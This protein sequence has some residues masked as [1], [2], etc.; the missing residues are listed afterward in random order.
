[1]LPHVRGRSWHLGQCSYTFRSLVV[2]RVDRFLCPFSF[3]GV[4]LFR[5]HGSKVL[6]V[7]G[8]LGLPFGMDWVKRLF[9]PAFCQ[10]FHHGVGWEGYPLEEQ[11]FHN[12]QTGTRNLHWKQ[13]L[14]RC[15]SCNDYMSSFWGGRVGCSGEVGPGLLLWWTGL[16]WITSPSLLPGWLSRK[17]W[18][19]SFRHVPLLHVYRDLRSMSSTQMRLQRSPSWHLSFGFLFCGPVISGLHR[20]HLY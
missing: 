10:F 15:I 17:G 16:N 12:L 7:P 18:A 20:Y 4:A 1:M 3:F 2:A 9:S 5:V 19:G 11:L 6:L 13:S 14:P 8:L